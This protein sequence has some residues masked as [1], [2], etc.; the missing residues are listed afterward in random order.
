MAYY[1]M[2][3]ALAFRSM[4]S[5]GR[6]LNALA[7]RAVDDIEEYYAREGEVVAG[8]VAGWNFGDGHFHNHQLLEAIHEQCAFEPG[9][10]RVITL[11]SQPAHIQ[12]QKYRIYDAAS[13]LLEEGWVDVA[14]M[15]KRGP[16]LEESWEFPVRV[17]LTVTEQQPNHQ[18]V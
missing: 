5:H 7:A 18:G 10:L 16:W 2:D 8:V 9:E 15:V 13:G 12:A 14:E 3:K 17:T 4:H 11:E 6:A 1:F